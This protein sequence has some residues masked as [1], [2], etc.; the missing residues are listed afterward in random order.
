M[1]W[2]PQYPIDFVPDGDKTNTAIDKIMKELALVVFPLLNRVRV[3]DAGTVAPNDPVEN[4]IWLDTSENPPSFKIYNGSA[5]ST[6]FIMANAGDAQTLNGNAAEAFATAGHNHDDD[7]EKKGVCS[8]LGHDHNDTYAPIGDYSPAIHTHSKLES[9]DNGN[10][11][12]SPDGNGNVGFYKAAFFSDYV[13]NGTDS[14]AID[15]RKSNKQKAAPSE[16]RTY[17]MIAPG[18]VASLQL[19]LTVTAARDITW[20]APIT[21]LQG[22]KPPITK[23]GKMMVTFFWDGSEYLG[24]WQGTTY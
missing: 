24:L 15:W 9:T 16:N 7:Y 12:L 22:E 18:G 8:P 17:T 20:D 2:S 23:E 6:N 13:D 3:F 14:V 5:W 11:E 4:A 21:W 1:A 10:V 19:I